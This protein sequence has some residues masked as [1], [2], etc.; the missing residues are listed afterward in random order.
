MNVQRPE[1]VL[2]VVRFL[3]VSESGNNLLMHFQFS[4]SKYIYNRKLKLLW[5]F[6]CID[7]EVESYYSMRF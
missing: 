6:Y 3:F 7:F 4:L 2:S 1:P 5:Q